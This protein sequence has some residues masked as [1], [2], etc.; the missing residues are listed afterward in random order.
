MKSKSLMKTFTM[1]SSV[2]F[3]VTGVLLSYF[4]ID[5]ISKDF[6]P[7]LNARELEPHVLALYRIIFVTVFSGLLVLF[8]LLS[9]VIY[10]TSKTLEKQ[11]RS[12]T[13]KSEELEAAY[14]KLSTSY[15]NTVIALSSAVDTRDAYTAGHSERVSKMAL[16]IGKQMAL[17]DQELKELELAALFHDIGKIGIPD[18]VLNK[19][20]KLNAAEFNYIKSHPEIGIGILKNI[21]FINGEIPII[22]HHHER[23]DGK[24]YPAG[25]SKDEIPLGSRIIAVAD[26]YDAMTSDR[27]YRR[28]L[29]H[30]AAI[31]EI[32][33]NQ[34]TQFDKNVVN[35]FVEIF[36][37][38]NESLTVNS[39]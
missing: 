39:A 30:D 7:G 11:N 29:S 15:R 32:V 6:Y 3:L 19:A 23:Y 22:L 5:H 10:R 17:T 24:G 37:E 27:P 31:E 8:A 18:S 34:N 26:T 2:A 33:K 28:S 1:Y 36:K 25:L 13:M 16:L 4:L 38:I 35:A 20:D 14:E 21:E 9:N 12:L